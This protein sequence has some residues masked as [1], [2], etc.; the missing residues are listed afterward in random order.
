[1]AISP[2]PFPAKK[3]GRTKKANPLKEGQHNTDTDSQVSVK[4]NNESKYI[5]SDQAIWQAGQLAYH[6]TAWKQITSDPWI[7]QT[8][9]G[10]NIEFT[11]TPFQAVVP[12]ENAFSKAESEAID[13]EVYKLL[14]K[15]VISQTLHEPGE[16]ISRIFIR[17]KKD[18][19]YRLILNLKKLNNFVKYHHFKM[20][21]IR[22]ATQLMKKNCYMTSIDLR[23][24]YYSVPV[25]KDHQKYLKLSWRNVLY[26]FT[27]LPNGLA[28]APRIFTKL[29]KLVYA[30]LRSQGH[31]SF[32]YIDDSYLQGDSVKECKTNIDNTVK[33]FELLGFTTHDEK[34]VLLPTHQLI[35]LGFLLNSIDM[36]ISLSPERVKKLKTACIKLMG[37]ENPTI[38]DVA[39]VG[40]MVASFPGNTFGPLF[41]R[42]LD[43]LKT[44]ALR[45]NKGSLQQR[46]KYLVM[47]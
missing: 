43:T 28:S 14:K 17:P 47:S 38:Q 15:G 39:H 20:E 25:C 46:F 7:T 29:L 30:T 5:K 16:F 19:T 9:M 1:V 45:T 34:S 36:T 21:T 12:C 2:A 11:S 23:D 26:R 6:K 27:C 13:L 3:R 41:Y 42:A 10:V 33:L 32:G 8:I 18:G 4:Y 35:L 40:L 31:V 22:T 44:E 37:K 24:A